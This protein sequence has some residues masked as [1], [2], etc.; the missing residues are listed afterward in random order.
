ML[1]QRRYGRIQYQ[2]TQI[3][4]DICLFKYRFRSAET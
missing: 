3:Y 2:G 1:I 4:L